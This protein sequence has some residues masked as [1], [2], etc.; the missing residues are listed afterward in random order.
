VKS[1]SAGLNDPASVRTYAS[2][3]FNW[4]IYP[5]DRL[6][7]TSQISSYTPT[8]IPGGH[9]ISTGELES[10]LRARRPM[11]LIDVL[12]GYH[13][14]IQG[15]VSLPG[16][17]FPEAADRTEQILAALHGD[18]TYPLVFFCAGAS[19]WESYNAALRAVHAGFTNVYWYRGGL[20]AWAAAHGGG[21]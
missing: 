6:R 18:R 13:N 20:E 19:C 9:V 2:E 7:E 15:A 21:Y 3:A 5:Q 8:S 16:A 10:A 14:T 4:N 12:N 11:A 1:P 17:G